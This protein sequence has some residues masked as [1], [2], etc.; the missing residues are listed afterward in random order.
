MKKIILFISLCTFSGF[1]PNL[2]FT[3]DLDSKILSRHED[4]NK[5]TSLNVFAALLVDIDVLMKKYDLTPMDW[6]LTSVLVYL[7]HEVTA[8][9]F[10]SLLESHEINNIEDGVLTIETE[11]KT[12]YNQF[13]E[14]TVQYHYIFIE[15]EKILKNRNAAFYESFVKNTNSKFLPDGDKKRLLEDMENKSFTNLITT[16]CGR[17]FL[18]NSLNLYK[19]LFENLQEASKNSSLDEFNGICG[20]FLT[21]RRSFKVLE[22]MWAPLLEI[23][24]NVKSNSCK[25]AI[26][27]FN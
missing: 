18:K 5:E 6:L 14:S 12:K 20:S 27:K 2:I 22:D 8:R 19:I 11:Q 1:T 17:C 26:V 24:D 13:M 3:S 15:I 16:S 25:L 7:S 9:R 4:E 21:G 10:I 23:F